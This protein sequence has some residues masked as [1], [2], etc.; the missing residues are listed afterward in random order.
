MWCKLQWA[1][2]CLEP[3]QA[4]TMELFCETSQRLKDS[5]FVEKLHHRGIT[6]TKLCKKLEDVQ[7]P[8][9]ITQIIDIWKNLTL[10]CIILKN[11]Q[12]Y[13]KNFTV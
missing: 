2:A 11:G 4:Y 12:A 3:S 5:I 10:S 1:V 6:L 13:L 8:I 9:H 7:T